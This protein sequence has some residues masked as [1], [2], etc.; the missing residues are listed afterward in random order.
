M[1]CVKYS[2]FQSAEVQKLWVLGK[3]QEA[4]GKGEEKQVYL[5]SLGNAIFMNKDNWN[6]ISL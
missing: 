3:R 1:N 2:V 6:P 5:T 4:K